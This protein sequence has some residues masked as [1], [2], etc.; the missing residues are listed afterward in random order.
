M[1]TAITCPCNVSYDRR[2][3]VVLSGFI[4]I[5]VLC[6]IWI[7]MPFARAEDSDL[8]TGYNNFK[9]FVAGEL[10]DGMFSSIDSM[11]G[12][13]STS[14]KAT[15][16]K[17]FSEVKTDVENT[18]FIRTVAQAI[19]GMAMF[20]VVMF[21]FIALFKELQRGDGGLDMWAKCFVIV[22]IG[23]LAVLNWELI[24]NALE[25]IGQFISQRVMQAITR[26]GTGGGVGTWLDTYL[27]FGDQDV[28]E[29]G[30]LD[31][32]G[33]MSNVLLYIKTFFKYIALGL[34]W[35]LF[36]IPLMMARVVLLT[37]LVEIVIRKMFFP[38]ALAAIAGE[39][40]R[41]PG[42][43]YMK[44]FVALY[45]RVAMCYAIAAIGTVIAGAI[46]AAQVDGIA[47]G[48]LQFACLFVAYITCTKLYSST[49][50]IANQ[51]IG[52]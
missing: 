38:L 4:A 5:L 13:G 48:I 47:Q 37:I 9:E 36:E 33:L 34:V 6:M 26:T 43:N 8:K 14:S 2:K 51:V 23:L 17:F 3:K 28:K 35:L 15:V 21:S 24:V 16:N 18:S 31:I 22:A 27:G 39:G 25:A 50:T 12:N 20:L 49:S 42:V 10:D 19:K 29:L 44:K 1:E 46:S 32:G 7:A 11:F 41:S 52:L 30:L 40:M 45:I